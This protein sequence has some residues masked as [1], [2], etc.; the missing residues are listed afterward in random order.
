MRVMPLGSAIRAGGSPATARRP[1]DQQP[2]FSV[3]F[4][5]PVVAMSRADA[6]SGKARSQL[7]LRT[8]TPGNFPKSSGGQT[9]CQ[10]LYCNGLMV[11]TA[12]QQPRP[13]SCVSSRFGR[14]RLFAGLPNRDRALHTHYILQSEFGESLAKL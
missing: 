14:Q 4:G 11:R 13:A 7:P 12:L 2:L 10:L 5:L 3:W 8:F 1:F 9:H 6:N